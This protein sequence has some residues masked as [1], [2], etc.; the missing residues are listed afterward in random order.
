MSYWKHIYLKL[1]ELGR[2]ESYVTSSLE[3][4]NEKYQRVNSTPWC[5]PKNSVK[6][7]PQLTHQTSL[8]ILEALFIKHS[9]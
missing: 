2:L 9:R 6:K 8:K 3:K 1:K 4:I 5:V 7:R